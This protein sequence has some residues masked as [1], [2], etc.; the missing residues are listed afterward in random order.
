MK[1]IVFNKAVD[2]GEVLLPPS[3]SV[4]HRAIIC[5]A[6]AKGK[7][8]IHNIDLSNDIKASLNFVKAI[9]REF[10]YENRTLTIKGEINPPK[11]CKIDCI[12]SGSTLRFIIPI[13]SALGVECEFTGSGRLPERPIGIY[14]DILYPV[15]TQGDK[16]PFKTKGQLKSGE[17]AMA[18]DISSQFIT[19]MLFALPLLEGDSEILITTNLESE[20][21]INITLDVMRDFGVTAEKVSYGYKIKGSQEYKSREYTVEADWSQAAFFLTMGAFCENG[22]TLKGLNPNSSQGDKKVIDIYRSMGVEIDD[23]YMVK[24]STINAITVDV[25]DIPDMVPALAC[26][27]ALADG[28]SKITNAKRLRIKESDRLKSISEAINAMGGNVEELEDGL[29]ITGVKTLHKAE[30]NAYNDHR[31]LMAVSALKSV[32]D[33]DITVTDPH[34]VN[35]SYPEFYKDYESL[36]GKTDV[37]DIG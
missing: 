4:S 1:K 27:M 21:Y 28:K 25:R 3:K 10:S 8:I 35:K 20:S 12:E 33:G 32:C 26:L 9:G 2:G 14:K 24:K 7:S 29:I 23:N 36:G 13:M 37:I 31:I 6:L 18:G 11:S 19:A 30:I 15:Q 5:A 22:I 34:C 17:F 16:L